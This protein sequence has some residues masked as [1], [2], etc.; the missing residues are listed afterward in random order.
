M[1][2]SAL[3]VALALIYLRRRGPPGLFDV[4]HDDDP[5]VACLRRG[6]EGCLAVWGGRIDICAAFEEELHHRVMAVLHRL[7]ERGAYNGAILY[8]TNEGTPMPCVNVR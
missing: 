1:K 8:S 2:F 3:V 5:A 6:V 4:E 7:M